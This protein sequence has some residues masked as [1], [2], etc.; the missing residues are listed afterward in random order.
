MLTLAGLGGVALSEGIR[1]LYG[2]ADQVL[3]GRREARASASAGDA[4]SPSSV[5]ADGATSLD[6]ALVERFEGDIRA[7]MVELEPYRAGTGAPVLADPGNRQLVDT[8]EALRRILSVLG[9]PVPPGGE[10]A[11]TVD[12]QLDVEQV[13]GYVAGVRG[14]APK[15]VDL[16]VRL[17]TRTVDEGGE[18]LGVDFGTGS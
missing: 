13:A 18:V 2:Q 1:F 14:R 10:S 6:H 17:K 4:S 3:R 7:L 8:A 15:E 12:V 5:S 11:R 16:K 9:G